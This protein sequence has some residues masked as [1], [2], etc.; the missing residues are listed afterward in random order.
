M[1]KWPAQTVTRGRAEQRRRMQKTKKRSVRAS[2]H[3]QRIK[4]LPLRLGL[5]DDGEPVR[6]VVVGFVGFVCV[7]SS[8]TQTLRVDGPVRYVR[9]ALP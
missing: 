9:Q 6:P 3:L 5:V 4:N 7:V 1:E 8:A 2:S